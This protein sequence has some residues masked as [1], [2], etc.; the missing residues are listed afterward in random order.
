MCSSGRFSLLSLYFLCHVSRGRGTVVV[1]RGV[2]GW[3]IEVGVHGAD[4]ST[5]VRVLG[6]WPGCE[7]CVISLTTHLLCCRSGRKIGHTE[8]QASDLASSALFRAFPR[9]LFASF[10]VPDNENNRDGRRKLP[11]NTRVAR[12]TR[13]SASQ[14][15]AESCSS[16]SNLC[17]CQASTVC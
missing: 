11:N 4:P 8:R 2:T 9:R 3:C 12:D 1:L 17:G 6:E 10:R 5:A 14:V 16:M 15:H 7:G 13:Q